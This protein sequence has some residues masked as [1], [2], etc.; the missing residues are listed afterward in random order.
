MIL[1]LG[2]PLVPDAGLGLSKDQSE[3][4]IQVTKCPIRDQYTSMAI[5]SMVADGLVIAIPLDSLPWQH[6]AVRAVQDRVGNI[7][8]HSLWLAFSFFEGCGRGV[9]ATFSPRL[10]VLCLSFPARGWPR[11]GVLNYRAERREAVSF[12]ER[13]EMILEMYVFKQ[14]TVINSR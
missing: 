6:Y 3:A 13:L 5:L 7:D 9:L 10:S 12:S 14:F 1:F 8:S 4:R 11:A 2:D